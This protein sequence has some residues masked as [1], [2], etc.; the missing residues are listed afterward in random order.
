MVRDSVLSWRH[1]VQSA[2]FKIFY[3]NRQRYF[4]LQNG[5]HSFYDFRFYSGDFAAA[6]VTVY[7]AL[8]P[9]TY[10]FRPSAYVESSATN[11]TANATVGNYIETG[12]RAKGATTRFA[13]DFQFLD[14]RGRG[15]LAVGAHFFCGHDK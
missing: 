1:P 2:C 6:D 8:Y 9:C 11:T 15:R 12:Y 13:A 4:R 14:V 3:H 5:I 7:A 10:P